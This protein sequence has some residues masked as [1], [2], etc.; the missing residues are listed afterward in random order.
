MPS[1]SGVAGVRLKAPFAPAV[2]VPSTLSPFVIVTVLFGSAVPV[3]TGLLLL[4]GPASIVRAGAGGAT[5]STVRV[6]PVPSGLTLLNPS[7][8]V[9]VMMLAPSASAAAGVKDQSPVASAWT[10][11]SELPSSNRVTVALG[12]AVPVSVRMALLVTAEGVVKTGAAGAVAS[13]VT[14]AVRETGERLP[15]ASWA[16]AVSV[17]VPSGSGVGGVKLNAPFWAAV[18][19]PR[20]TPPLLIAT[21]LPPSAVPRMTRLPSF[22]AEGRAS[23]VGAAGGAVS[24]VTETAAEAV[25]TLPAASRAVAVRLAAASARSTL[26]VTV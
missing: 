9:A 25:E 24:I 20:S 5:V 19:V 4:V 18:V 26:G 22:V 1:P 6:G 15:A 8:A 21:T 12:S 10:E 14:V 23:R 17:A 16:V 13:T 3:M 7:V 2:T 11:P